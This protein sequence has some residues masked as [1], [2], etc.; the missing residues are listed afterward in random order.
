MPIVDADDL[1]LFYDSIVF[2]AHDLNGL[3]NLRGRIGRECLDQTVLVRYN[4]TLFV[5]SVFV[6]YD[7]SRILSYS[8]LDRVLRLVQ[9]RIGRVVRVAHDDC[10]LYGRGAYA[11]DGEERDEQ[12]VELELHGEMSADLDIVSDAVCRCVDY[13]V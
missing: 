13:E 6:L 11:K 2:R 3:E 9:H 8:S 7:R 4:T 5:S 1:I 12:D 10:L